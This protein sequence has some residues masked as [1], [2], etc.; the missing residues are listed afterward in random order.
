MKIASLMAALAVAGAV[1]A[2]V[3][4][5]A[6]TKPSA[7]VIA[8]AEYGSRVSA[9]VATK[10]AAVNKKNY[11]LAGAAAIAVGLGLYFAFDDGSRG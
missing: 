1:V 10:N 2:P 11:A 6:G 5:Q 3:A 9:Q 7:A 4:A 8:P